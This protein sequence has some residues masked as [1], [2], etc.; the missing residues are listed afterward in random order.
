MQLGQVTAS[1]EKVENHCFEFPGLDEG[2]TTSLCSA[3]KGARNNDHCA[4][5]EMKSILAERNR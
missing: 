2:L 4:V 1:N 5:K 3:V